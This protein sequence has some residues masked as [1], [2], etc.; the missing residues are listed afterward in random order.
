MNR[1]LERTESRSLKGRFPFRLGTT[2]YIKPADIVPNV[3]RLADRVDD[4]EIVLFEG[5]NPRS[6]P[7]EETVRHLRT[8]AGEKA[9]T[10][11]VHL[12]LKLRLGASDGSSRR[13]SVEKVLRI[14]SLMDPLGPLAYITHFEREPA[15][16]HLSRDLSR[17][18]A[19]LMRSVSDLLRAGVEPEMLCVE[20][21]SY[22]FELVEEIIFRCNLSVCLD[23]G[24][25]M[26][27]RRSA[28]AFLDRYLDRVR[29]VH[30]HGVVEGKDHCDIRSVA[31]DF[32]SV[33]FS[34]LEADSRCR[35]VV[36]LEVFS[37]TDL[38]RSLTV[39][40][41]YLK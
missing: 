23:V 11:T 38:E 13:G 14:V 15:T 33:L 37:E 12:P 9:L 24:H 36:T 21:L 28:E 35:R 3:M 31:S 10:Y 26:L 2:S 18:K 32:L 5:E 27:N 1:M 20:T 7:G 6:L 30:L 22:P 17:W 8:V 29:V 16:N 41:K 39:M 25:L 19:A 4:I 40:E 34:R